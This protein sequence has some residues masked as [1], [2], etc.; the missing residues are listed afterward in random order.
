MILMQWMVYSQE[1][2]TGSQ[3]SG[4]I[5]ILK[6]SSIC[7]SGSIMGLIANIFLNYNGI[8]QFATSMESKSFLRDRILGVVINFGQIVR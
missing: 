2:W 7:I 8:F 3:N 5:T 1:F 4:P 6:F